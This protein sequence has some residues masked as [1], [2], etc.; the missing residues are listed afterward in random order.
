MRTFI[1]IVLTAVGCTRTGE[2]DVSAEV[3]ESWRVGLTDEQALTVVKDRESCSQ[4]YQ[5]LLDAAGN[6][7]K[8]S[9]ENLGLIRLKSHYDEYLREVQAGHP[10]TAARYFRQQIEGKELI[11]L[12][13]EQSAEAPPRGR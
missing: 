8:G 7:A 5:K 13:W 12:A 10:R 9:I 11:D 1:L 6:P 4:M 3:G 2:T